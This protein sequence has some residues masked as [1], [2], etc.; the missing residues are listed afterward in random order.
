MKNTVDL[1]KLRF[2]T[3]ICCFAASA[4]AV[5]TIPLLQ[6]LP[7]ISEKVCRYIVAAVFW[8]GLAAG[9]LII[10]SVDNLMYREQRKLAEKYKFKKRRLPGIIC[11][12]NKR[13]SLI[14][15]AVCIVGI[16]LII[17]DLIFRCIPEF[18]LFPII[19]ITYFAFAVHCVADGNNYKL[20]LN[21]KDGIYNDVEQ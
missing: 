12:S 17:G 5:A 14:M 15:Y 10:C 19:A 1:A 20:Y 11:F 21:V 7:D 13:T 8:L 4:L 3:G 18:A 2:K 9:I 16:L 6:F